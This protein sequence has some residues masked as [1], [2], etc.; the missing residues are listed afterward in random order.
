MDSISITG[1][2]C[3]GYIGFFPEEKVLG[4]WF[5]VDLT[6]GL[7]LTAASKSD[8]LEDTVDYGSIVNTVQ[9]L[10]KQSKSALLEKVAN[11][12]ATDILQQRLVQNVKVRLTKLAAPIPDFGGKVTIEITRVKEK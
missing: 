7:D 2:R 9:K 5:E 3:Y 6:L 11:T 12:I 1:I 10:V 4:Q 8:A